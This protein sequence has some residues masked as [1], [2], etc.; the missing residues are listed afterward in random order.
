MTCDQFVAPL[1]T[2]K[3]SG[4]GKLALRKKADDIARSNGLG[5]GPQRIFGSARRDRNASDQL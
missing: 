2:Q 5:R 1:Q 4:P 3:R